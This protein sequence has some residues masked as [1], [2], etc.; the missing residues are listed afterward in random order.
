[1]LALISIFFNEQH[2]MK[3]EHSSTFLKFWKVKARRAKVQVIFCDT[4]ILRTS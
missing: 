4:E 2:K 3:I 1:M